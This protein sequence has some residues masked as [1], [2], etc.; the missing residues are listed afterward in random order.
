M[1]ERVS[2]TC[3]WVKHKATGAD[4]YVCANTTDEVECMLGGNGYWNDCP[5]ERR[6]DADLQGE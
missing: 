1:A 3:V 5:L 6:E 2:R 4:V